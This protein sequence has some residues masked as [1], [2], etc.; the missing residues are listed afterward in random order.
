MVAELGEAHPPPGLLDPGPGEGGVQVVRAVRED[1]AGFD[2]PPDAFG[3]VQVPGPDRGG[4]AVVGVVHEADRLF[5]VLDLHHP[6]DRAEALLPH[7]AHRV[8]HVDEDLGG[9]VGGPLPGGGKTR[10]VDEGLRPLGKRFLDLAP[11][12]V[13]GGGADERPQR[14]LGVGGV[15]EL[16]ALDHRHQ[17]VQEVVVDLLVHVDPLDRGAGLAGVEEGPVGDVLGGIG[18]VGVVG[19]VGGVLAA[20][21]EVHPDE[22]P[23]RRPLHRPPA[24]HRAG[25]GDEADPG[26][27]DHLEG[28]LVVGVQVLEDP[29]RQAGGPGGLEVALGDQGGLRRDLQDHAVSRHQRGDHRVHRGQPGVVP[30]GEHEYHAERLPPDRPADSRRPLGNEVG[31]RPRGGLEHVLGALFE[32]S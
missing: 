23:R 5:V 25:E 20:E 29:L 14:G 8:V 13:G 10:L 27:L 32:A 26:V 30:G 9:E 19:H 6:D 2:P 7:H 16:V 31:E 18:E 28:G 17:R 21:L 4:E 1:G 11:H 24:G 22:P 3:A 15:S 12:P